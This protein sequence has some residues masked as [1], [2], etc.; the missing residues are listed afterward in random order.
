MTSRLLIAAALSLG[1]GS[2]AALAQNDQLEPDAAPGSEAMQPSGERSIGETLF[3]DP[4]T[5]NLR[6]EAEVRADWRQ[7]TMDQQAEVRTYCNAVDTAAAPPDEE[8]TTG[9][10]TQDATMDA[11]SLERSCGW[12]DGM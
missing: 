4:A 1:L 10:I 12:V 2:G 6:S 9:S 5:G 8:L 11:A 7:L 3:I